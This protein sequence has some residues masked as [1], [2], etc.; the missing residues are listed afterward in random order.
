[1][2]ST[3]IFAP[4]PYTFI[5]FKSYLPLILHRKGMK[6]SAL[7]DRQAR[8]NEEKNRIFFVRKR[9]QRIFSVV[10]SNAVC[11]YTKVKSNI[12]VNR[13][14]CFLFFIF[15]SASCVS[16]LD[17]GKWKMRFTHTAHTAHPFTTQLL[18]IFKCHHMRES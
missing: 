7:T 6:C 12:C 16:V 11:V 13:I 1:M 4:C 2:A 17:D 10:A 8:R 14:L 3:V 9:W 15:Y 5:K 18:A